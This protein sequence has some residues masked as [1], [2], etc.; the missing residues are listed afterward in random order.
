MSSLT[1]SLCVQ[2]PGQADK[3]FKLERDIDDI[4]VIMHKNID[5]M[6]DR[7][8]KIDV[9]VAKS[10]DLSSTSKVFYKQAKKTKRCCTVM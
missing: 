3:L 9:L 2:D 5:H 8:E 6:L 10:N 1:S 7:G 4:K